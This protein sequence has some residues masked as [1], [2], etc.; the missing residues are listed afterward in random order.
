MKRALQHDHITIAHCG[1][2]MLDAG[3]YS[4]KEAGAKA[5]IIAFKCTRCFKT[6]YVTDECPY[7]PDLAAI[8]ATE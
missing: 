4:L 5:T 2:L 7:E 6:L 8:D 1:Q 3:F